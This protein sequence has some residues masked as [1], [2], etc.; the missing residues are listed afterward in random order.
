MDEARQRAHERVYTARFGST[1]PDQ[2]DDDLFALRA[3]LYR[4][5]ETIDAEIAHRRIKHN[6]DAL[7]RRHE[8]EENAADLER[9]DLHAPY[10]PALK[11]GDRVSF[12]RANGEKTEGV[13]IKISL[14]SIGV[15][16]TEDRGVGR[17]RE[18]GKK[19]RVHPSLV[20]K[21]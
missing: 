16:T 5:I 14:K 19:W 21:I 2:S 11:I 4:W 3:Q 18:A 6:D 12:G 17:V 10:R 15:E 13:V 8:Q 9:A 7:L 20:T 1:A